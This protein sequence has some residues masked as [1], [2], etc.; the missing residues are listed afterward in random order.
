MLDL[1][2]RPSGRHLE[3][4][5]YAETKIVLAAAHYIGKP[6]STSVRLGFYLDCDLAGVITYGTVP[7]NNAAAICGPDVASGVLELTRLA[8]YDWAPTNSESWVIGQSFAWLRGYR[9]DVRVLISYADASVG[10]VGTIYQATNWIYTGM[11]GGDVH[12][13]CDDGR[14]LHPRTTGWDTSRLPPGR[15]RTSAGKH[16]YVML[17]GDRRERRD[18]RRQLRWKSQPYPKLVPLA[19]ST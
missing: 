9:R 4:L 5:S 10:H 6:G 11:S 2:E 15:W 14:T 12:W 17:L 19:E 16:R 7:R 1:I 3:P 8:L 13:L 18:L